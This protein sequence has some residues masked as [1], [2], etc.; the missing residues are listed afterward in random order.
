MKQ[1]IS[2]CLL[3]CIVFLS[4][5]IN[6]ELV[7]VTY[8]KP[9]TVTSDK[10]ASIQL[11]T[12][13]VEGANG[14]TLMYGG[15]GVYI[16][17]STGPIPE[18]QFNLQD[19]QT[20]ASSLKDELNRLEILNV[21]EVAEKKVDTSNLVI[22]LV[23]AQTSHNPNMH[24]YYLNVGMQLQY[25]GKTSA[26]RYEIISSDGESIWKKLNTNVADGKFLAGKKLMDK[27]IPDIQAFVKEVK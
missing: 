4:G 9:A 17:I 11:M 12:G 20:F 2:I 7:K 26:K 24:E 8:N 13:V 22:Q 1:F 6:P 19:Q 5:C 10:K 18:F 3:S 25:Q 14:T 16:P 15:P 21:V 27:L 23:F